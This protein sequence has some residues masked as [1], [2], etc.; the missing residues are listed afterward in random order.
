MSQITT[1]TADAI[2]TLTF[3]RPDKKNAFLPEMYE[4]VI[5]ALRAADADEGVR[6][7]LV[8]G[9]GDSFSAGND[10]AGFMSGKMDAAVRLLLQL[11]EQQK[12]IVAAVDG[13]A[14]GIGTTLLLHADYVVATARA[15]FQLPFVNL[16]L[17]PEGGSTVLLPALVGQARASEWLLFG[18][19]FDAAQAHAAGLINA[20]VAPEELAT[21]A[22]G[23]ALALAAKPPGALVAAKRLLRE[24][25]RAQ[26]RDAIMREGAVFMERL[27]APETL[28]TLQ[29]FLTRR[30]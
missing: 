21:T 6:A 23:R 30:K 10:I 22:R 1:E 24:P 5:E 12:P 15:R 18:D 3:N 29:A 27:Q 7:I 4:A 9:A 11:V 2:L 25:T 19:P 26:V 17:T 13:V 8:R 14:I 28:A 16:G 20:V